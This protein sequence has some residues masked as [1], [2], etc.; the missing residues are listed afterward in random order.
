MRNYFQH[1]LPFWPKGPPVELSKVHKGPWGPWVDQ[2]NRKKEKEMRRKNEKA[3]EV[4]RR[5][6]DNYLK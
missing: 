3:E 4:G 2:R 5:E 1:V 6:S